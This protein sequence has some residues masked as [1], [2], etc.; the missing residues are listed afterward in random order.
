[1]KMNADSCV[2][3]RE[4]LSVKEKE[5]KAKLFGTAATGGIPT[6]LPMPKTYV[7]E[8]NEGKQRKIHAAELMGS[9]Y[10]YKPPAQSTSQ[11]T[12]QKSEI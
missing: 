3:N 9:D 6:G 8:M 11:A 7:E 10:L 2:I 5:L 12:M 1:L 4:S